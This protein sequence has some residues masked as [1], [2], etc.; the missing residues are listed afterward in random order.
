MFKPAQNK[1]TKASNTFTAQD[2]CI[3]LDAELDQ[4]WNRII[5][6][7]YSDATIQLSGKSLGYDFITVHN[8]IH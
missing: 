6:A 4:F 7:H 3:Y 8:E 2:A 1:T 5:F